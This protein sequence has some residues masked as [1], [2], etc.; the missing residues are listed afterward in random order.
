MSYDEVSTVDRLPREMTRDFKNVRRG[1]ATTIGDNSWFW[2]RSL[3]PALAFGRAARMSIDCSFWDVFEAASV[4]EWSE[5]ARRDVL[6]L[7]ILR[8]S[9]PDRRRADEK[10]LLQRWVDGIDPA[11]SYWPGPST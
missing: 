1:Y 4:V 8:G 6:T 2:F 10:Q 5:R 3:L 11:S 7:L 9:V